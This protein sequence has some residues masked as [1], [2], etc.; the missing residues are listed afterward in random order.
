M[1]IGNNVLLRPVRRNDLDL[2]VKWMNDPDVTRYLPVYLPV[3]EMAEEK[4]FEK[5]A[6]NEKQDTAFFMIETVGDGKTVGSME[7]GDIN[8]KD[9]SGMFGISIGE[10]GCWGKGI[11]AEAA[12]LIIDYGFTQ[13]NLHRIWSIVSSSNE[14]SLRLHRK[15]GFTE[16][17]TERETGYRDGIWHGSVHFGMLRREWLA[18]KESGH[19]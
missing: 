7:L 10:K 15:V 6:L 18:M 17:G 19:G 3:T 8:N 4:W 14:R 1:L 16:E 11:G 2:F 9:R 5:I 13:L 12:R